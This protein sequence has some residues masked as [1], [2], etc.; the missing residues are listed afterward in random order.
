MQVTFTPRAWGEY[1]EWI[2]TDPKTSSKI[3]GLINDIRRSPF[4]GLGKPEPLRGDRTGTWSRRITDEHR[5][6]YRVQGQGDA[7]RVEIVQCRHHY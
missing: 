1:T 7:Q 5:L 4:K 3:N 6:L 2:T